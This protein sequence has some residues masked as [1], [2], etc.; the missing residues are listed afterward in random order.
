MV[1]KSSFAANIG[2]A[3]LSHFTNF[4]GLTMDTPLFE[5][6]RIATH[7]A[8]IYTVS[9]GQGEPVLLLH[10]FPQS[11]A[12]WHGIAPALTSEYRVICADLRGYGDS[13]K[14]RGDARHHSYS[15][16]AMA[17]DMVDVMRTLG[18]ERFHVVGHDRGARVAHRLARDHGERV[19]SLT[20]IDICP[21]M[22]M[23]RRT[24]MVFA[25]AYYHW[26]LFIQPPPLPETM[27]QAAGFDEVFNA[28]TRATGANPC[29]GGFDAR[30]LREY[31][32]CFDARTVH[33]IC[34]D[35]RA[36]AGID[37]DHDQQDEGRKLTLPV[38]ALWG[39]RGVVGTMF[40][41]L[42]EWQAVAENV[43]G[44]VIDC[45]HFVPEERPAQTLAAIQTFLR[46]VRQ[47]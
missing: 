46:S 30:A 37:L 19:K 35:Y 47:P 38:L 14:P 44:T 26:F 10:G 23:Y 7:D 3:R 8:N 45:G 6:Q 5:A 12:M 16:R 32:R 24:D 15:K 11:H 4:T 1:E 17:Q 31:R 28:L 33:A 2:V 18:H 29:E 39:Q 25:R 34:E 41:C 20:V 21:T 9:A 22:A 40:D 43:R 27:L 42:A 36:S 13:S